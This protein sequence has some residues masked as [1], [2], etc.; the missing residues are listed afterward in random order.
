MH[1]LVTGG[2]GYIGKHLVK[3]LT[4][5]GHKVK[6]IG[7]NE[8]VGIDSYDIC[9]HLGSTTHNYHI[10][11][12]PTYDFENNCI[13]LIKLLEVLRKTSPNCKHVYVSTFF[14]NHGQPKGLYGASKL[15]AENIIRV[16]AGLYD[17]DFT[18]LRLPNVYGPGESGG[19]KKGSLNWMIERTVLGDSIQYYAGDARREFLYIDDAIEEIIQ[20][21][22]GFY[23]VGG[24]PLRMGDFIK[25]INPY[26]VE[27]E[28]PDFHKR[29]GISHYKS[30]AP[31]HGKI[32]P[33][34]G[35]RL[36]KEYYERLYSVQGK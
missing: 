20:S 19:P 7:R 4:D 31:C 11:D 13:E 8:N 35:I 6:V 34:E 16:Y 32:S 14:V 17:F 28:T 25:L 18:I 1:V 22:S 10:I 15:A 2:R 24:F 12:K 9:Y 30:C 33:E 26:A 5:D 36:T 27:V 21:R 3:K 23:N 29:V